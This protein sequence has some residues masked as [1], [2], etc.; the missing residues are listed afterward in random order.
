MVLKFRYADRW[1][2]VLPIWVRMRRLNYS[3]TCCLGVLL[4]QNSDFI[5]LER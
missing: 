3:V 5:G 1:R 4:E 2:S